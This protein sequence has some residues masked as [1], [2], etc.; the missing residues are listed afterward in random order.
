MFFLFFFFF[1]SSRRRHTRCYRDWSSDVCSSD[2]AQVEPPQARQMRRATE[3]LDRL[4]AEVVRTQA[5]RPQVSE[6]R[7]RG[8]DVH[9]APPQ[10]AGGQLQLPPAGRGRRIEQVFEEGGVDVEVSQ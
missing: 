5:E 7:R 9:F 4:I 6:V 10:R 2:L 8:Q 3:D 1:F